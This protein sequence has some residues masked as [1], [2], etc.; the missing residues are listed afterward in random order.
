MPPRLLRLP[1]VEE[2]RGALTVAEGE[3]L[4]FSVARY[5]V[6]RGVPAGAARGQHLQLEGHELLSCLAGACTAEV[7]WSGGAAT[8]RLESPE[9]ALHVPAGIWVE[10]RDFTADAVLLVLC[11]NAYDPEDQVGERP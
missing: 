2:A 10:C 8:Y 5:F 6:V 3:D 4:P 1:S 7:R 11:S 9:Q